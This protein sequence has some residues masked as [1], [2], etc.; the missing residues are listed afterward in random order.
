MDQFSLSP[1]QQHELTMHQMVEQIY[2]GKLNLDQAA[3]HFNVNRKT[4]R[5]WVD[6]VE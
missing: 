1:M 4:V 5:H 2:L 3:V 6:K